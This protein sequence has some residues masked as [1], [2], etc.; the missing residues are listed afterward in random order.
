[1]SLRRGAGHTFLRRVCLALTVFLAV[2][3]LP[4]DAVARHHRHKHHHHHHHAQPVDPVVASGASL[5]GVPWQA[6]VSSAKPGAIQ[7]SV[8]SRQ[9]FRRG[10]VAQTSL[11]SS[12]PSVFTATTQANIDPRP[13]VELAGVT[14]ESVA[15]LQVHMSDGSTLELYP[16][17]ASAAAK[18]LV[19]QLSQVKVFDGFFPA[20]AAPLVI[21]AFDANNNVLAERS[22]S[23]GNF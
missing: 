11:V 19:P 20:G 15:I 13:E 10:W 3:A 6:T 4:A 16:T 22:S 14:N 17:P 12:P 21:D 1:M 7:F 9:S 5:F 18:Q 23:N 2:L 8:D